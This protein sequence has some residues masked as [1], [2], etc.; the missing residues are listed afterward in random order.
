MNVILQSNG[1]TL[2][3]LATAGAASR[4]RAITHLAGA[5]VLIAIASAS[6]PLRS[7][8]SVYKTAHQ[9]QWDA[10]DAVRGNATS[11]ARS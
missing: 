10:P 3:R 5:A 8:K 7:G 4:S 11:P 9:R 1:I 2:Q 6:A